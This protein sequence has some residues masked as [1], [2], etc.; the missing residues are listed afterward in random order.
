MIFYMKTTLLC[1]INFASDPSTKHNIFYALWYSSMKI[2]IRKN[3][4]CYIFKHRRKS[5]VK[6]DR[7][8]S[9]KNSFG[10][11][12]YED[13]YFFMHSYL[14]NRNL[15]FLITKA[16]STFHFIICG[17]IQC[18]VQGTS[19]INL[20]FNDIASALLTLIGIYAEDITVDPTTHHPYF[21]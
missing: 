21:L 6:C 15:Y 19:L 2:S 9:F 14:R 10:L 20:Y 3:N 17:I 7:R 11:V 13:L 12:S 1:L 18:S 16:Q 5:L 8:I 4:S